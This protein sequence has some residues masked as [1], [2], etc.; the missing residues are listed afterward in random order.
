MEKKRKINGIFCLLKYREKYPEESKLFIDMMNGD[1][2]DEW[3]SKLPVFK[4]DG[5]KIATRAASGKV[6]NAIASSLP[7]LIGGS[8]D[9]EP[10][11]NTLLKRI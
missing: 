11:N 3:K 2:G 10:S 4:D 9:L 8:A 5:K 7:S 6:L 1:L